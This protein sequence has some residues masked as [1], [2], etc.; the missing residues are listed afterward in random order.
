[1][2][3]P[4]GDMGRWSNRDFLGPYKVAWEDRTAFWT[5]LDILFGDSNHDSSSNLLGSW[6]AELLVDSDLNEVMSGFADALTSIVRSS[7]NANNT[8]LA[9]DAIGAEIY[10]KVHWGWLACPLVVVVLVACLL[11]VSIVKNTSRLL[12]L[13][14][15]LLALLFHG[16]EG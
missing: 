4:Y 9:G 13:K 14:S 16:L 3:V 2:T 6:I 12:L 8:M 5:Y 1:M 7:D 15:S 10:I 11:V